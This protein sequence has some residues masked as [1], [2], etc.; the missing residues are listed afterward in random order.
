MLKYAVKISEGIIWLDRRTALSR[1]SKAA[2]LVSPEAHWL[3]PMLH[4][5]LRRQDSRALAGFQIVG[6]A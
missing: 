5:R 3:D 2:A 1:C 4:V 6:L